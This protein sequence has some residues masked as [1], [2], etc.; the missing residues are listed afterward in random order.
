MGMKKELPLVSVITVNYNGKHFLEDCFESL[1]N[2][3]YPKDKLEIIMVDNGSSDGSVDYVKNKFYNIKLILNTENNYAKAN[4]LGIREAKGE[5]IALINNDVKIDKNWLIT[6]IKTAQNDISIGAVGSKILFMDGSIQSMGHRECPN[7]YW[8]D[9]GF[10]DKDISQY[11]MATEVS[12]IC[13]CSVLYRMDCLKDV[14][15]LD[16]DF[17]MFMEDVDMSIRCKIKGWKLITCPESTV[18]HKFHSTIGSENNA[19]YWQEINRLLLIAKHWPD[20]LADALCSSGYFTVPD[21]DVYDS[22][23]DISWVL[24]RV[25]IKLIKEHGVEFTNKLSINIFNSL[26]KTYNFEKSYLPQNIKDKDLL[27]ASQKEELAALKNELSIKDSLI[28]SKE[29]ELCNIYNSRGYRYLL[30]PIWNFLWSIKKNLIRLK[31]IFISSGNILFKYTLKPKHVHFRFTSRCNLSCR[32]CDIWKSTQKTNYEDELSV[33]E[34]RQIIDKLSSWLGRFKLDLAGGEILLYKDAIDLINYCAHKKIKVNL[35]T[36]ATLIDDKIAEKLINSGLYAI[37]LSL[38]G[39]TEVHRYI[40]NQKDIYFKVQLAAFNLVNHRKQNTPYISISTVITR[41]NLDEL[42]DLTKL[43]DKWGIDGITFQVLDHNFGA[44][45]YDNWFKNNEFWPN[46]YRKVETIINNL[47]RAKK[48]EAKIC[49]SLKYLNDIKSYY[50]DPVKI[51]KYNCVTGQMN[52]IVDEFGGT[53][54]CWNMEPIGNI[55]VQGPKEIWEGEIAFQRRK[56]INECRRTCRML[57]CNY[58]N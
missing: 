24:G 20:K 47:I 46:D 43:V 23:R 55:L 22:D 5:Y 6:L 48:S 53:R 44:E 11:S 8:E 52:F 32:H 25:F 7:F 26:R 37:N 33:A 42:E 31:N 13:G 12:S 28:A 17:N 51:T 35:T 16:E 58:G 56:E 57:N 3:Y 29:K 54:L 49:N 50:K 10:G 1:Y 38:D 19:K 40:R 2:L 14:G 15:L 41:Y 21:N 27:I 30:K 45:Y 18:Y 39:L 9:I 36:N 34:W 4:N